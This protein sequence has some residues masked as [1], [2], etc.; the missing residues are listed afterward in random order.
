MKSKILVFTTLILSAIFII[1]TIGL[2]N[3]TYPYNFSSGYLL[4]LANKYADGY[5]VSEGLKFANQLN[6]DRGVGSLLFNL[7]SFI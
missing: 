5:Q 3:I 7:F 4:E 6:A 1:L 2:Q